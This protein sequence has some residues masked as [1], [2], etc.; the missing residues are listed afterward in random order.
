MVVQLSKLLWV[1]P[2]FS[3]HLYVLM[4]Q[5]ELPSCI[6]PRLQVCRYPSLFLRHVSLA[7]VLPVRRSY[8]TGTMV[9]KGRQDCFRRNLPSPTTYWMDRFSPQC[10]VRRR[11]TTASNI[12][13]ST[14]RDRIGLGFETEI[15]R[16][17]F[18]LHMAQECSN[19]LQI[20]SALQ[21]VEGLRP[22]QR[23]HAIILGIES[24]ADHPELQ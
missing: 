4:R 13:R 6:D 8:I 11:T 2:Q 20:A 12:E 24:G 23:F 3:R 5:A 9:R 18:D 22:A 19:R 7:P 17:A 16:C 15:P 10:L 1:H 21:D 14:D